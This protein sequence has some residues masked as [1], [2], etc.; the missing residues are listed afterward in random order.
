MSDVNR[1][2]RRTRIK[3]CGLT[4]IEDVAVACALGVDAVGFV[5]AERSKRRVSPAQVAPL[6]EALDPFV[7]SVAL[8]M[9]NDAA[10]VREVIDTVRPTILQFHGDEDD[11]FCASFGLPYLKAVAMGG[12]GARADDLGARY[13]RATG[14][15]FDSHAAGQVGGSGHAFDWTRIP[16]DCPRPWLLAGGL[17]PDNVF[18]AI[19]ATYCWGVDVSSGIES[20]PGEKDAAKMHRFVEAVRRADAAVGTIATHDAL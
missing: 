2:P 16:R 4:R 13:A 9:D 10:T 17:H 3:F 18:E 8:F 19:R 12:E 7:A 1:L 5:F 11:A 6:R 15:L 14:F 20:A